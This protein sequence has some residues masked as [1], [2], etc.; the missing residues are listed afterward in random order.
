M[1]LLGR[2]RALLQREMIAAAAPECEA[3]MSSAMPIS[4]PGS[5]PAIADGARELGQRLFVRLEGRPPAALVGDAVQGIAASRG[6]RRRPGRPAPVH[7]RLSVKLPAPMHTTMKILHVHAAV[8]VR[9]AAERSGSA[10]PASPAGACRRKEFQS[11]FFAA[12]AAAVRAGERHR[13]R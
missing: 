2:E 12:A 7:C 13:R 11:G 3:A 10:A 1:Q 4:A 9:A 6:A 8:G 5:K